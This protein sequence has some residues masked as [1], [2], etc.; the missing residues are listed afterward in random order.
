MFFSL[1]IYIQLYCSRGSELKTCPYPISQQTPGLY[2]IEMGSC[3]SISAVSND[4]T[5]SYKGSLEHLPSTMSDDSNDSGTAASIVSNGHGKPQEFDS[6]R[7]SAVIFD[8]KD[9]EENDCETHSTI[10]LTK[11]VLSQLSQKSL[12]RSNSE[13]GVRLERGDSDRSSSAFSAVYSIV[14]SLTSHSTA[15]SPNPSMSI[16]EFEDYAICQDGLKKS[17]SLN[18]KR[19]NW[20][21][22]LYDNYIVLPSGEVKLK[23]SVSS[24]SVVPS[25]IKEE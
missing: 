15:P 11:L 9:C 21:H 1:H 10:S 24:S 18:S 23:K 14:S 22:N 8:T 7:P 4:D 2:L 6:G 3:A 5:R 20:V 16:D 25:S 19:D 17:K 13:K 12:Y